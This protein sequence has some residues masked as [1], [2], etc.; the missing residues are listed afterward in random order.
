MHHLAAITVTIRLVHKTAPTSTRMHSLAAITVSI[1]L[2]QTKTHTQDTSCIASQQSLCTYALYKPKHTLTHMHALLRSN[3][4][5]HTICTSPDT[6]SNT[7]M[8]CLTAIT[9]SIRLV[10]A[11]T[12]TLTHARNNH[13]EN[14]LVQAQQSLTLHAYSNEL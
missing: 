2:V 7:C 13:S 6:H 1:R 10:Q 9:V 3:H 4:H 5:D 14:T 8:H 11:Q 12:H